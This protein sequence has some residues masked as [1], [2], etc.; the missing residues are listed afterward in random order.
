MSANAARLA[1]RKRRFT[2][3]GWISVLTIATISLIYY[4][5][6]A[7]LYILATVGV[8]ILLLFVA[9]SD[10]AHS[11]TMTD[12]PASPARADFSDPARR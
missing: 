10:L 1:R 5:Q 11:D 2:T 4:E 3:I 12:Q 7:L 8:S 6:P 9:L